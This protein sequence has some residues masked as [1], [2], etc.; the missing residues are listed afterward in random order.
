MKLNSKG[1]VTIPAELRHSHGFVEGDEVE[2]VADGATLRIVHSSHG[3]TKGER[4]VQ[5][6]QGRAS[7]RLGTD[8]LMHLLR[9][10]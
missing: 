4:V 6:M 3:A 8:E 7:T 9:D 1:Q 5:R 2:V 10:D